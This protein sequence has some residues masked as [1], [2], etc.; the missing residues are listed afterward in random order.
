M[1]RSE[2][3]RT[4]WLG[5]LVAVSACTVVGMPAGLPHPAREGGGAPERGRGGR[6]ETGEPTVNPVRS[7]REVRGLWVVRSSLT[8]SEEVRRMVEHAADAGFNTLLVQVRGRGDAFY[9][10]RWEPRAET[11]EGPPDFDPLALTIAEAHARG[12]AVHAWVDTHLVW[13]TGPLPKSPEHLVNAHPDWLAVPREL[14]KKLYDVSPFEPRYVDALLAYARAHP[15]TV[16]GLYTSPSDPAVQE[17][18]YDVWMDLTEHYDLDGIHFDYIRYPSPDF[19]YSRGAL[20][21]FRRWIGPRLPPARFDELD[22][23]FENDP[24]AFVDAL[25]GPWGEFRR[26]QITELVERGYNGVKA[27]RPRMVVSAAVFPD[28]RDA[29]ENRFQD[30]RGWLDARILDVAVP[31]A[32]TPDDDRFRAELREATVSAGRQDR[33]WAGIGAYLNG[34]EGTLDKIDIARREGVGGV[35]LFSYD[36]A[37]TDGS[38]AGQTPFLDRVGRARFGHD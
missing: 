34:L 18:V 14:G 25:P 19:D 9:R 16:E 20:E 29:Y 23:A 22:D 27:R 32:Y 26:A 28:A 3:R 8:S 38:P 36:W 13:G 15:Q 7:F 2:I 31:M 1:R 12:M 6:P 37:V 17:R 33:V 21:R 10:S 24:Y 4:A 35:V 5:L 11:I 30:W